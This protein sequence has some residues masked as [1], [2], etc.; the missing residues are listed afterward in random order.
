MNYIRKVCPACGSEFVVLESVEKRAVYCTLECLLGA[1]HQ[2][3]R[4]IPSVFTG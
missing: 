4:G 1:Q 3:D 2:L